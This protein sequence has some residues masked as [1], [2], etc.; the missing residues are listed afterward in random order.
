MAPACSDAL[1]GETE[2]ETASCGVGL[3]AGVGGGSTCGGRELELVPLDGTEAHPPR[4]TANA[5]KDTTTATGA[6]T[7]RTSGS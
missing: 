3:G 5:S 1:C 2:I 4:T 7:A 6:V